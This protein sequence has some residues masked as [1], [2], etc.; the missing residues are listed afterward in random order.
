MDDEDDIPLAQ[1]TEEA[2]DNIPLARLSVPRN[3]NIVFEKVMSL[4]R[5]KTAK[6]GQKINTL[7]SGFRQVLLCI[8]VC[9]LGLTRYQFSICSLSFIYL[10]ISYLVND[11]WG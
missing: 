2:R 1:L 4:R 5:S 3:R 8:L 9:L 6:N 10:Q 7:K 11:I